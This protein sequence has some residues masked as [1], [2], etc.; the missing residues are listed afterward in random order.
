MRDKLKSEG[1]YVMRSAG[2]RGIA[3]LVAI[4]DQC[5]IRLL[6]IKRNSYTKS[7]V[8]KSRVLA[9]AHPNFSVEFWVWKPYDGWEKIFCSG[10]E[11]CWEWV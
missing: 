3:D 7:D 10:K 2:S 5:R 1:W 9:A 8:E 6:Q 4:N 11:D